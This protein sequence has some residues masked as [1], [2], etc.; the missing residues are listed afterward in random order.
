MTPANNVQAIPQLPEPVKSVVLGAFSHALDDVFLI[1]VPFIVV[2]FVVALFLKEVPLRAGPG[3][4]GAGI[5]RVGR[6]RRGSVAVELDGEV[7]Q[8]PG[9]RA[10]RAV[11]ADR[12]AQR[13]HAVAQSD[14]PGAPRRVGPA[15]AV[16][17]D[18]Q[19]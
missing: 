12:P 3:A 10:G 1:G 19:Q 2:G 18:R 8:E 6:V 15:D 11:D 13:L 9:A 17:A 5:R 16:V 4:P 14:Q 7:D